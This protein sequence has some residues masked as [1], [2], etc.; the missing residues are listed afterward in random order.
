MKRAFPFLFFTSALIMEAQVVPG[1]NTLIE[2]NSG[3]STPFN[4]TGVRFQQV[5]AAQAFEFHAPGFIRAIEFRVDGIPEGGGRAF[6]G[7]L[8][9]VQV[10]LST[11]LRQPDSLSPVFQ[12]NIGFNDT[13]LHSGPLTLSG[14][15]S[16]PGPNSFDIEILFPARYYYDPAQGNL[17][18]DVRNFM[19]A[20]TSPF[21]AVNVLGDSVSTVSA[22]GVASSSGS[23]STLG[24]VTRFV[25]DPVPEPST[26]ALFGAG[27]L[28]FG[29]LERK[30]Q[31]TR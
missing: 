20:A 22:V 13:V 31:R 14:S 10:N 16:S 26:W 25:I 18:L 21:D 4:Q 5:Y 29:L 17:L 2:G 9:N 28:F 11:T 30:R 6:F 7:V 1:P 15:V 19:G 24:L 23:L 12:E 27:L 8:S 3:S